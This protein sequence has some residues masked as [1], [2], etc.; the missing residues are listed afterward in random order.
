M[1]RRS[2][3][4]VLVAVVLLAARVV[5]SDVA[6]SRALYSA[7]LWAACLAVVVG[8]RTYR[9]TRPLGWWLLAAGMAA[10]AAASVLDPTLGRDPAPGL[11]SAVAGLLMAAGF[12]LLALAASRFGRAQSGGSDHGPVLDTTI[13]A[14]AVTAVIA[15]AALSRHGLATDG[16]LRTFVTVLIIAAGASWILAMTVRLFL[17]GGV[18]AFSGWSLLAASV[19]T[20]VATAHLAWTGLEGGLLP[21]SK[22]IWGT[23]SLLLLV[24]ALHPSMTGLTEPADVAPAHVQTRSLLL[25]T[26][27]LAPPLAILVRFLAV[28]ETAV[29][30]LMAVVLI[31]P[32]VVLRF[33][34]LLRRTERAQ[35]SLRF[36]M[37]HDPLT[38]LPNRRLLA[39]RLE[40]ALSR[41][42]GPGR[43]VAVLFSDLD[44][45]K[46]VNDTHG[47][48]AGDRLLVE[49]AHRLA[50]ACRAADTV[51]RFAGDEFVVVL[52]DVTRDD[53]VETAERLVASLSQPFDVDT[54]RV[55]IGASVGIALSDDVGCDAERLMSAADLAMYEAK[56]NPDRSVATAAPTPAVGR[57]VD[58]AVG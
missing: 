48:R 7:L 11:V 45:F 51:A 36:Q 56:R 9:P 23:S 15:E 54:A 38:Q 43:Q 28:G 29:L 5:V 1:P 12:P 37:H 21:A 25:G 24:S 14:M 32:V 22:L 31:A 8:V 42:Y 50:A 53:A 19:C 39:D 27:L 34:D 26:A 33:V 4:L 16:D 30:S 2:W 46:A 57:G 49:A 18:R 55:Q 58:A 20:L 13:L 40:Q 52:E 47:H 41:R 44:G 35:E 3:A 10:M 6:L 17:A